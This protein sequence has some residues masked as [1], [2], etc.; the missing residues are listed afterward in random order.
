MES[1][2]MSTLTRWQFSDAIRAAWHF[3]VQAQTAHRAGDIGRA[4]DY[5]TIARHERKRIRAHVRERRRRLQA[6][7]CTYERNLIAPMLVRHLLARE[8]ADGHK[9]R[10]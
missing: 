8:I 9:V 6:A 10:P 3:S 5:A 4:R 7:L 2:I 1:E